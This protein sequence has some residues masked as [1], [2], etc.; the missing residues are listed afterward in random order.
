VKIFSPAGVR[1]HVI[2]TVTPYLNE[3]T[4]HYLATLSDGNISAV[5]NTLSKTKTGEL[6]EKF[7]IEVSNDKGANNFGGL[8]GGEKRKVRIATSL[9]LQ[10]LVA[11]RASKPFS[12]FIADEIDDA[13]DVAGL[14]R[15]MML[16]EEKSREKGTVLMISHN[17]ISDW[18]REQAVII[19][20]NGFS[21]IEGALVYE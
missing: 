15:L 4:S 8:S 9:A 19:K 14:E 13:L 17:E 2:D 16:L 10:D 6:R 5:W 1:A 21:R 20:E 7:I 18:C 3:R 12:L 11:S